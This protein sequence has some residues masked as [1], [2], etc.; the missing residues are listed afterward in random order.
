MIDLNYC[1]RYQKQ[2]CKGGH[3][4]TSENCLHNRAS[5]SGHRFHRLGNCLC[6][7]AAAKRHSCR[8]LPLRQDQRRTKWLLDRFGFEEPMLF[9][10]ARATI[11]EIDM[12]PPL[13]ITPETTI[14]ETLQLMQ[15]QN[16][17]SYGVVNEKGQLLGMVTRSDLASIGLGDTAAGIKLLRDTPSGK[18]RK[19]NQRKDHLYGRK[20]S[21][22]RQGQHHCHDG[23][24]D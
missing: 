7:A 5:S 4:G 11:R 19:N 2:Y 24:P 15:Q 9:E 6:N 8:S 21:L 13:T 10:D 3:N 14:Y 23:K 20:I 17:Q 1:K 18:H 12:D 22:Q 16:K